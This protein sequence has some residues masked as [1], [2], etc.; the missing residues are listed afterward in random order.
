MDVKVPGPERIATV[1]L[2]STQ[3]PVTAR[4]A[5]V[6]FLFQEASAMAEAGVGSKLIDHQEH[7]R[8]A[9]RSA[10]EELKRWTERRAARP[11]AT[12]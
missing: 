6:A 9:L 11:E 4:K 5:T 3:P 7:E 8:T 12:P 2:Q 1:P 10:H